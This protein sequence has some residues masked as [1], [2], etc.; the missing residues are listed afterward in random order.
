[1]SNVK[2]LLLRKTHVLKS[3]IFSKRKFE[4]MHPSF[5]EQQGTTYIREKFYFSRHDAPGTAGTAAAVPEFF[6]CLVGFSWCR[7]KFYFLY[8]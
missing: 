2:H 6:Y 8:I 7:E 1:M 3:S 4:E 5:E